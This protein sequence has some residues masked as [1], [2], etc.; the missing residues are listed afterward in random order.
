MKHEIKHNHK[1]SDLKILQH[2]LKVSEK[3]FNKKFEYI[4]M[5]QPT[6]PL[7][8]KE[9]VKKTII[10]CIK[11]N[12]DAVWTISKIDKKY[13]PLKQLR[14]TKD[15]LFL[16]YASGKR[17]IA[18]QQLEETYIRNGV[19]YVF[20]RNTILKKKTIYPKNLGFTKLNTRQISIDNIEDLRL[21]KSI[22]AEYD[23]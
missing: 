4:V 2:S 12:Y 18:R 22:F 19:A 1:I 3:F 7:R 15:K 17:V 20:S 6:S 13:H 14:I 16:I 23:K 5:L 9:D 11:K 8:K 21:A 10:K